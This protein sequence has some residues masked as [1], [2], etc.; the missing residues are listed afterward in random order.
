MAME[1]EAL[2]VGSD[3]TGMT[4][5]DLAALR[6]AVRSLEHPVDHDCSSPAAK[7]QSRLKCC[8]AHTTCETIGWRRMAQQ[9]RQLGEVHRHPPRLISGEQPGRRSTV[10][11]VLRIEIR[12]R[13]PGA[14]ASRAFMATMRKCLERLAPPIEAV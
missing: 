9:L 5:E 14:V 4:P 7:R 1:T 12:E 2:P 10:R 6:R 13:L 8:D 3:L 11:L